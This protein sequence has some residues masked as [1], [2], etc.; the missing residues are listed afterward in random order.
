M[1]DE[2]IDQPETESMTDKVAA[3]FG[4]PTAEEA[5]EPAAAT[6]DD[7]FDLEIDGASYQVPVKL[8]DAFMR[9]TDYTQKTQE[10]AEQ[11]RAYEHSSQIAT[12]RQASAAFGDSIGQES[13]EIAIIE[14]YLQQASKVDWSSM[15]TDQMLRHKVE[16]DNVKERRASL[17]QSI[18]EKRT[19][20]QAE[21]AVKMKELRD[22]AR[23]LAGKSIQGFNEQTEKDIRS[24]AVSNGLSEAEVDNVLLD[25]RSYKI[26]WKALQFEKVQ[27][28]T[29]K[30]LESVAQTRTLKPGVA[31]ERMPAQVAA[32]LNL[33]RALKGATTSGEKANV[34]EAHL[35]RMY[36]GMKR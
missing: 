26:V 19:R 29:G 24:F 3:K 25:P 2:A 31:S 9:N 12:E 18:D 15:S 20:F 17:K 1:T 10:L 6:T 11:R 28:G 7:L 36:E 32:K 8:K 22:K 14:A 13:N 23:E 27:A 4:F 30:A 5:A 21:T 35:A 33:N 34:I 16:L